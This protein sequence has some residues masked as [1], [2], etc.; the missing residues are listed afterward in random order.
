MEEG[1]LDHLIDK[2]ACTIFMILI[3]PIFFISIP[4]I[5]YCAY[6]YFND[7]RNEPPLGKFF[8]H[9]FLFLIPTGIILWMIISF[10][11]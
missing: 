5:I 8:I 3:F 10:F 11:V 4:L 6:I 2:V 9:F 1:E 7:L